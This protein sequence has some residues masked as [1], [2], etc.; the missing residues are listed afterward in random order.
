M[1]GSFGET[2]V[3]ETNPSWLC[4]LLQRGARAAIVAVAIGAIPAPRAAVA[5]DFETPPE[6]PPGN[7]LP[8]GMA[9]G[10]NY[11]V[12]DPVR[13][14]GLMHRFVL[15]SSFG[16]FDAYGPLALAMRVREIAALTELAKTST[17]EVAAGGMAHGVASEVN[18]AVNVATHPI[19]TVAGIPKGVAHLFHGY[20]DEAKEAA[21]NARQA[22]SNSST[23][24]GGTKHS[25]ASKGEE[26]AKR[27]ADHYFGLSATE[28]RWYQKFGVDPYTDNSVLRAAV[29]KTARVDAAANFGT[30]FV[31]LPGIPGIGLMSRATDAIYNEDPATLRARARKTLAGYGLNPAEIDGWQNSLILS[32]TRQVLL[33]AAAEA[34]N[35]VDGRGEI[36]R[37]ALGL[38]SEVEAQVYLQSVGLLV[39][40]HGKRPVTAVLSGVRLPAARR[41]DGHLIVCGAFDA[42]YWTAE[43][44]KLEA[45]IRQV[46]PTT[47]VA[48]RELWLAGTASERARQELASLGWELHELEQ[49]PAGITGQDGANERASVR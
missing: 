13:S 21:A 26:A 45:Q 11:R 24:G 35:G 29:H 7:L 22:V 16:R 1:V 36:F 47:G 9:T 25:A 23:K 3:N 17:I 34:L 18:T 8:A 5:D 28:R 48:V 6:Q 12:V 41:A 46:L 39:L 27:Y 37:H 49:A 43:V 30:R 40:A 15:D 38:T 31:G 33:L 10:A 2:D 19:Q 4:A 32:P 42:V 14:D 44:A 20:T